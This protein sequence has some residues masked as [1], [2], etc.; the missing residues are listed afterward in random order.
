MSAV[1]ELSRPSLVSSAISPRLGLLLT[2]GSPLLWWFSARLFFDAIKG[3][4][5]LDRLFGDGPALGL[6]NIDKLAANMRHAGH[7]ISLGMPEQTIEAGVIVGMNP[8]FIFQQVLDWVFAF[9]V[10]RKPIPD[11]GRR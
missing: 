8:A 10:D 7:F 2:Q 3:G 5:P 9:P 6:V 1:A 4:D 11:T